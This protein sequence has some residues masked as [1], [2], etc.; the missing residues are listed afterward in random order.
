MATVIFYEKPGCINNTRQKVLLEEAGHEVV[1]KN[2]LTE[3]WTPAKLLPFF[4]GWPVSE[5]FNAAAPRVKSGEIVPT[6]LDAKQALELMI[7]EPLL[8]RRPLMQVGE[9]YRMG[10]D[11]TQVG[12]WIGLQPQEKIRD[13]ETCPRNHAHHQSSCL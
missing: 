3:D 6:D 10:F 8:I 13:L 12:K 9:A 5:W 7:A 1:A 4:K 2:L 11:M